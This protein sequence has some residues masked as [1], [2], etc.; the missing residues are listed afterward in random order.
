[1]APQKTRGR[2]ATAAQSTPQRGGGAG[3]PKPAAERA[4]SIRGKTD[5]VGGAQ[6]PLAS[7]R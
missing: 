1:M 3:K 2:Q 6:T 7:R 4:S 5:N